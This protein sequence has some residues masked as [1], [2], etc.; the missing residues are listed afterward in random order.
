MRMSFGGPSLMSLP[1]DFAEI[2]TLPF[3]LMNREYR[4]FF[5]GYLIHSEIGKAK[6]FLKTPGIVFPCTLMITALR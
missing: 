6:G 5:A 4:I 3:G 2:H 1:L